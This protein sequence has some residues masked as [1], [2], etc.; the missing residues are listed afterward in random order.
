MEPKTVFTTGEV[1]A[2]CKVTHRT[3]YNWVKSGHLEAYATPGRH[4]RIRLQDLR[5]FLKKHAMPPLEETPSLPDKLRILV[6]DDEPNIVKAITHFLTGQEDY[7]VAAAFNGFNAGLEVERFHP[8]LVIL[9]LMMP[10][11]DGFEVCKTIKSSPETEHI[12]VLVM[13]GYAEEGF[14][15]KAIECGADSWL[16]KPCTMADLGEKIEELCEVAETKE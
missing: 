4:H 7:E 8:D 15:S 11:V 2:H 1:A 5:E 16:A 10:Y 6:V 14:I 13:T 3:V 9:D 12:K